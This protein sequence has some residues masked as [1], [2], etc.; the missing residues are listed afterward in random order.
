MV[1]N[2]VTQ[3]L[4]NL[5]NDHTG[6]DPIH[7]LRKLCSDLI[8]SA[9]SKL[10]SSWNAPPLN[11]FLLAPFRN[12]HLMKVDNLKDRLAILEPITD[13]NFNLNYIE[14][15]DSNIELRRAI[16]K[17]I[18][19]SFFKPAKK[20]YSERCY[21]SDLNW[22]AKLDYLSEFGEYELLLP[23]QY[24]K[25]EI[26]MLG[27]NPLAVEPLIEIFE[28]SE[29]MIIKRMAQLAPSPCSIAILKYDNPEVKGL[30]NS[31]LETSENLEKLILSKAQKINRYR[32]AWSINSPGFQSN[33]PNNKSMPPDTIFYHSALFN[34]PLS[35]SHQMKIDKKK[36]NF[37]VDVMPLQA[38]IK[39]K[40]SFPPLLVFFKKIETSS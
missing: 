20:I 6:K 26:E 35:G 25:K 23:E 12:I 3:V 37:E 38:P 16:A 13:N 29:E 28:V 15:E 19:Y 8:L 4:K 31:D 40:K 32:I 22:I 9:S 2:I 36:V 1:D 5:E 21:A 14:Q 27:F 39:D 17:E 24:F 10:K 18:V 34:K 7:I 11:P 30:N 33:L